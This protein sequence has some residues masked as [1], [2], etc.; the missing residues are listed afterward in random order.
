M[1]A[2]A[3]WSQGPAALATCSPATHPGRHARTSRMKS[4]HK[5]RSSAK[6]RCLP[7]AENGWHGTE[8]VQRGRAS[9]HISPVRRACSCADCCHCFCAKSSN[10]VIAA[11]CA[12]IASTCAAI[13]GKSAATWSRRTQPVS[14]ETGAA[15]SRETGAA[16]FGSRDFNRATTECL[17]SRTLSTAASIRSSRPSSSASSTCCTPSGGLIMGGYPERRLCNIQCHHHPIRQQTELRCR[18]S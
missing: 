9:G 3:L 2:R 1:S 11:T 12:A 6:P 5:S 10:P 7:A 15:G 16:G 17:G 18:S 4:G 8:A 14:R 13:E